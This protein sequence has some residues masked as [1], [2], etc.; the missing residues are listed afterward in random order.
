[1]VLLHQRLLDGSNEAVGGH[2]VTKVPSLAQ[3][4]RVNDG[5]I[6][7]A[8]I[9]TTIATTTKAPAAV[10]AAPARAPTPPAAQ[11][12]GS[13]RLDATKLRRLS[14]QLHR[15]QAGIERTIKRIKSEYDRQGVPEWQ[16]LYTMYV[17]LVVVCIYKLHTLHQL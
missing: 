2:Q 16:L 6:P 3:G 10:A 14:V 1:M 11:S 7:H 5:L 15:N 4:R 9:T 17:C 13:R 12:T 8:M